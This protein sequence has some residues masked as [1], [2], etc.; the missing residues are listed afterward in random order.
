MKTV[1]CRSG[2]SFTIAEQTLGI[3][4]RITEIMYNPA[5]GSLHE[6]IELQNTS[7]AGFDL[8]GMY[9]D[10]IS[11][12]FTEG[13]GLAGVCSMGRTTLF[14]FPVRL[15]PV[16]AIIVCCK[17]SSDCVE[18]TRRQLRELEPCGYNPT[19]PLS[20]SCRLTGT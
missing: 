16:K 19:K 7:A 12:M 1:N 15:R 18:Q 4:L 13:A 17:R 8:S 10:G 9:F 3:P 2:S 6:F 5:G 14:R 11:F 20:N